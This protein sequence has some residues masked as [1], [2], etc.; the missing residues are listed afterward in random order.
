MSW[1]N[2]KI[3]VHT[4][5]K[6]KI[7]SIKYQEQIKKANNF[8]KKKKDSLIFYIL[9]KTIYKILVKYFPVVF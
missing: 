9:H 1:G 3:K 6:F 8:L 7:L 5:R 2:H 4:T